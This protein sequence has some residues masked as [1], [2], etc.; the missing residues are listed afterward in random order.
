MEASQRINSRFVVLH[1]DEHLGFG[2][3][4]VVLICTSSV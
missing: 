2:K 4:W 3:V 1:F